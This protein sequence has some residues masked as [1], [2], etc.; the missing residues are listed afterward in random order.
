[1]ALANSIC[2]ITYFISSHLVLKI[3]KYKIFYFIDILLK[4]RSYV[5]HKNLIICI[6][7]TYLTWNQSYN[8]AINNVWAYTLSFTFMGFYRLCFD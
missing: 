7:F 5:L 3:I 1:M 2:I 8:L 6:T 4:K